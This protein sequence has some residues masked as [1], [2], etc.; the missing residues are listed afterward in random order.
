MALKIYGVA[1]SRTVRTLWMAAELGI[2][3]EHVQVAVGAEGSRK[4]EYMRLNPNGGV[5]FIEDDG[6]ILWESLAIN[7]YL[8]RKHGGPLAG[9]NLAED[10]QMTMWSVWGVAS[11]EP[12]AA[13]AMYH[14]QAYAPEQRDPKVA[15]MSLEKLREPRGVLEA[16]LAKGGGH[17]VGGRF[18]VADLNLAGI[19]FYLRF[20]PQA[21][22]DKPAIR[23]WHTAA[24][25]R[26][27]ARKAF[28]LRG[29]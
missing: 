6:L 21:L 2:P 24:L 11:V 18:T 5:P 15:L 29:D 12:H 28:A 16:A 23:A 27:A 8:A 13:Q 19:I 9:T 3:Y 4:P 14:T 17:L 22:A 20:N 1:R 25:A 26:P 10:A 7:L